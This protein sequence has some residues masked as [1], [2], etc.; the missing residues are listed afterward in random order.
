[1]GRAKNATTRESD[2]SDPRKV[3]F[4]NRAFWQSQGAQGVSKMDDAPTV[5]KGR[6]VKKGFIMLGD[7]IAKA[8]MFTPG[9]GLPVALASGAYQAFAP[10]G[11]EFHSKGP[12]WKKTLK[13][14][15][16]VLGGM[17][18]NKAVGAIA[19]SNLARKAGEEAL[20]TVGRGQAAVSGALG[21]VAPAVG[22]LS[23]AA[24]AT[25]RQEQIRAAA[26][27]ANA[28]ANKAASEQI[29]AGTVFGSAPFNAPGQTDYTRTI[30][31]LANAGYL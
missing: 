25:I 31:N 2:S 20:K 15:A 16:G 7:A 6:Y 23:H 1:M 12:L 26:R 9:V 21:S 5:D 8:A 13:L 4:G 29:R 30:S 18:L 3:R 19:N 10:E 24:S 11:S 17:V 27:A 14:G 22:R 28:A